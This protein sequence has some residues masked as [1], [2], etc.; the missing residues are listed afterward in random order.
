M[1][2]Q[3]SR[4]IADISGQQAVVVLL[5]AH[6]RELSDVQKIIDEIEEVAMNY[7]VNLVVL[8]LGRQRRL[9]SA[10][11]GK[12][13]GLNKFLRQTQIKLR[14]CCLSAEAE[15]AFKICRLQKII[16]L[17]ATEEKALAG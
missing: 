13:I 14:V 3:K 4:I 1:K 15:K 11:L 17:Y 5:P 8:R 2:V 10:F 12:L 6:L 7:N 16:P 9:T